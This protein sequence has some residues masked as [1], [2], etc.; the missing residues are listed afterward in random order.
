MTE[1]LSNL[2]G[3]VIEQ[4][5]EHYAKVR[6]TVRAVYVN[7]RGAHA[8]V[9]GD[10][11]L[12]PYTT[13]V[14]YDQPGALVTVA[15][16]DGYVRVV[17]WCQECFQWVPNRDYREHPQAEPHLAAINKKRDEERKRM[18]EFK[19]WEAAERAAGRRP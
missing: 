13:V 6:G 19:A 15:L 12:T 10:V 14:S 1:V 18:D 17:K 7:E 11:P 2:L 9:E 4:V 8:L 5:S 16:D 3:E